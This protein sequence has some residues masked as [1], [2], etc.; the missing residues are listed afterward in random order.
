MQLRFAVAC[1]SV[2][3]SNF[4]EFPWQRAGSQKQKKI[5]QQS[6]LTVIFSN[7]V[8]NPVG[9]LLESC[10]N[11]EFLLESGWNRDLIMWETFWKPAG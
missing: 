8:R 10:C 6:T 1:G 7:P 4:R 2:L 9:I 11:L 5:P 3:L